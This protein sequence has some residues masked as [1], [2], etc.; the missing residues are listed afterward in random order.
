M[1]KWFWQTY[2]AVGAVLL[3]L[4]GS[5][6]FAAT[7]YLLDDGT[8]T[9]AAYPLLGVVAVATGVGVYCVLKAQR[10]YNE[11]RRNGGIP[12]VQPQNAG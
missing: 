8:I 1:A 5:W 12:P 3:I 11:A 9:A 4:G 6:S 10:L 7:A 2:L